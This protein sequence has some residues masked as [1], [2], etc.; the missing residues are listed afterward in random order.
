MSTK[1]NSLLEAAKDGKTRLAELDARIAELRSQLAALE[2]QPVNLA[3]IDLT[4]EAAVLALS[5]RELR[6]KALPEQIAATDRK[7]GD[8]LRAL[9]QTAD[10]IKRELAALSQAEQ[11]RTAAAIAALIKPYYVSD[12]V[13]FALQWPIMANMAAAAAVEG[14]SQSEA[15]T[16][17]EES[18]I[19]REQFDS[20][21]IA[22]VNEV[23][24]VAERY[25]AKGTFIPPFYL[26][27]K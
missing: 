27:K 2:S 17:R 21:T 3:E 25:L 12:G 14:T 10:L 24:A 16:K 11:Q 6:I 4:D 15:N 26:Q 23:L 19:A 22:F 1:L 8:V 13:S 7:K 18:E 20:V 5:S 9:A